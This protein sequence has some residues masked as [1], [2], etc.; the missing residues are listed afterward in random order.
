MIA[1]GL[2]K[3]LDPDLLD[4]ATGDDEFVVA[5]LDCAECPA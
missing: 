2:R 4:Q 1:V 3:V 5:G